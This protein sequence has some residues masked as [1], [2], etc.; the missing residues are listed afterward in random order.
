LE[1]IRK[2][3][4]GAITVGKYPETT[5][6]QGTGVLKFYGFADF[7]RATYLSVLTEICNFAA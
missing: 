3:R 2:V 6:L 4:G 1:K 5:E 7:V